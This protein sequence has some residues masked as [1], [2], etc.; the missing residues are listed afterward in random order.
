[1]RV[2]LFAPGMLGGQVCRLGNCLQLSA[3]LVWVAAS[4]L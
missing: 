4:V 2:V 1:M 3:G